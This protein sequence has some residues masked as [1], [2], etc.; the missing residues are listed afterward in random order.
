MKVAIGA[1]NTAA[2]KLLPPAEPD[3]SGLG[4]NY[5]DAYLGVFK[6]TLEDGRKILARRRGLRIQI[7]IGSQKGS[8]LL[9]R[10]EHGPDPRAI[11]RHAL[12]EAVEAAG[13]KLLIENGV[14]HLELD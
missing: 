6:T 14:V 11:L 3:G 8:A 4:I 5:V 1:E 7:Q 10:L 12:H 2:E 9:R 13:A